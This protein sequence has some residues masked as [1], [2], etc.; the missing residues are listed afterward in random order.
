[1]EAHETIQQLA[2]EWPYPIRYGLETE[3]AYDVL[4]IGGGIAGCHAAINAARRGAKVAVLDKGSVIRSG[5]G[6]GGCDHWHAACTN[7]CSKVTPEEL[8]GIVDKFPFGV[9]SE[10]GNG[11]TCYILAQESYDTLLDLEQMGVQIR[12]VQDEFVGADFRD[13]ETKLLFAYDYENKHTIRVYGWGIKPALF[14]ELERLG[15][16]VYDRVMATSLLT[17]GGNEAPGLSGRPG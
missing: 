5:S 11:I 2:Q 14:A 17:E 12:D 16:D 8:I 1:M 3:A 6:G 10:Y 15:V 4:V 7:P 9:T 13:E